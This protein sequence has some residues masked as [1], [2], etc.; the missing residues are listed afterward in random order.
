MSKTIFYHSAVWCV[1]CKTT[2]PI[3]QK[4]A[5]DAG[6]TFVEIDVD[7]QSPITK[8]IT[9]VPTVIVYEDGVQVARLDGPMVTR[10]TLKKAIE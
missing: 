5:K 3:A 2:K 8:D 9:S 4:L 7:T 6:A 10:Q 1:S